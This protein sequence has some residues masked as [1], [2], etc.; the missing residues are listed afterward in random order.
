M[1]LSNEQ[2]NAETAM[3]EPLRRQHAL[4]I[5]M[6]GLAERAI[7]NT[8]DINA[9]QSHEWLNEGS[10]IKPIRTSMHTANIFDIE[11]VAIAT[12]LVAPSMELFD[13][14]LLPLAFP[15]DISRKLIICRAEGDLTKGYKISSNIYHYTLGVQLSPTAANLY[16]SDALRP[17]NGIEVDDLK[18]VVRQLGE[19]AAFAAKNNLTSVDP[20]TLIQCAGE[21]YYGEE[22]PYFWSDVNPGY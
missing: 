6:S 2:F 14:N 11:K 3:L 16:K 19:I 18:L 10:D 8:T 12:G 17:I 15:N 4:E 9:E 21:P 20:A 13:G 22:N 5:V 1:A 7:T